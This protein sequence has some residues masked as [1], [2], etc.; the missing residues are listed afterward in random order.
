VE[1]SSQDGK[2]PGSC[3]GYP[4]APRDEHDDPTFIPNPHHITLLPRGVVVHGI[5]Q[6]FSVIVG[7]TIFHPSGVAPALCHVPP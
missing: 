6:I 7:L 3:G 4:P 5:D 1:Q 2:I